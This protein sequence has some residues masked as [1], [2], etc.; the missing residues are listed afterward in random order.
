MDDIRERQKRLTERID[1]LER[2]ISRRT[3][4][5]PW[6]VGAATGALVLGIV[7]V[8]MSVA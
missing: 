7:A 2:S 1:Q 8:V 5:T 6:V 4:L 3:N